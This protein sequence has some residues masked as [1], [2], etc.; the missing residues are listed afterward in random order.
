MSILIRLLSPLTS[1]W[2]QLQCF[3]LNCSCV[4]AVRRRQFS[5]TISLI[6]H[7]AASPTLATWLILQK[8]TTLFLILM[9]RWWWWCLLGCCWLNWWWYWLSLGEQP[10]LTTPSP[11]CWLPYWGGKIGNVN[12]L[13]FPKEAMDSCFYFSLL[14]LWKDDSHCRASTSRQSSRNSFV[15][16]LIVK[17]SWLI[18]LTSWCIHITSSF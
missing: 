5:L 7:M 10:P 16:V 14:W 4:T 9:G 12:R 3:A 8:D 6:F 15:I 17:S 2:L 1:I 18:M 13:N 11:H